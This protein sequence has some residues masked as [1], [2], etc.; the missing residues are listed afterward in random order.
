MRRL[1]I[2]TALGV[3]AF[4][5]PAEAASISISGSAKKVK[6]DGSVGEVNTLTIE[7]T[8]A[9]KLRIV[10]ATA[11]GTAGGVSVITSNGTTCEKIDAI[12][13]DCTLA[14]AAWRFQA[15]LGDMDDTATTD[16][17]SLGVNLRGGLG[18][19]TL[20]GGEGDDDLEGGEGAD[21]L[22]GGLGADTVRGGLDRPDVDGV[23]EGDTILARDG[24]KDDIACGLGVDSGKADLEDT[25]TADCESVEKPF[26]PQ[27]IASPPAATPADGTPGQ[28][29]LPT[30]PQAPAGAPAP[31]P[32]VSVTGGVARGTV[33]V[34][35]K[36]KGNKFVA[37]DPAK[38]VP[39]GSTV[40][41]RNG[42][43]TLT[44]AADLNGKTQT[45]RFTGGVFTVSQTKSATMTTVLTLKGELKCGAGSNRKT[46]R[47]AA[48][49]KKRRLW[50]SGHGRFTT[51]GKN[52]QAT[53]RGTIWTVEDRCDGTL[54]RVERG[55]VA[56]K[57]FVS[58][59]TRIVRAG[60]KYLARNRAKNA[61]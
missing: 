55:A 58:G 28:T 35:G 33:L 45:A 21:T 1:L 42:V 4:A 59:K 61:R 2:A 8:E 47:A 14:S 50:G 7:Q 6:F 25:L 43:V 53:V 31:A 49:G 26:V 27:T 44:S 18:D 12:T 56:V 38:P 29:P 51:R 11:I 20:T 10:D 39:V 57:D 32:G 54:T 13:V 3:L 40:D 23:D 41:A 36:A 24:V 9:L 37:L 15:S 16:V 52:S 5:A 60:G 30:D 46:A 17:Q 19:D 48:K 22:D 34:K